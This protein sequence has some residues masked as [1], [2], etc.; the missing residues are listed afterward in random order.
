MTDTIVPFDS[1]IPASHVELGKEI[2]AL[3]RKYKLR[4]F[5]ARYSPGFD[6]AWKD[7]VTVTWLAGRHGADMR[8]VRISSTVNVHVTVDREPAP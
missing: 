4:N 2:A 7:D 3:C 1:S 8:E 6:D 5:S